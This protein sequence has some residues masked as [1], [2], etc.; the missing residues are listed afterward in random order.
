LCL[1]SSINIL[2]IGGKKNV[3]KLLNQN[4]IESS[5]QFC[6][7]LQAP[8]DLGRVSLEED[9]FD[10]EDELLVDAVVQHLSPELLQSLLLWTAAHVGVAV[11]LDRVEAQRSHHS[12]N[13]LNVDTCKKSF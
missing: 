10:G 9:V 5:H 1:L 6:D 8:D 13:V 12:E 11:H 3:Q 2:G 4:Q 7:L